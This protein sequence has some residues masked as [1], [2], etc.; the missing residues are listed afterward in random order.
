MT[1]SVLQGHLQFVLV[2]ADDANA[3]QY[4]AGIGPQRVVHGQSIESI[5]LHILEVGSE[6]VQHQAPLGNAEQGQLLRITQNR[7]YQ[8]VEDL[9]AAG[10]QIQMPVSRRIERA[11]I[12]RGNFFQWSSTSGDTG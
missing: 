9:A 7:D 8:L 4:R 12:D 6:I 5:N 3:A 2:V 1:F 11:G 10:D